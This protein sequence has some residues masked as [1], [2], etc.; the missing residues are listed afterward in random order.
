M[1]LLRSGYVAAQPSSTTSTGQTRPLTAWRLWGTLM[2]RVVLFAGWQALFALGFAVSGSSHPWSDSAAWWLITAALANFTSLGLLAWL[3][4]RE[5][6]RLVSLFNLNHKTWRRDL[7]WLVGAVAVMAPLG[8]LPSLLL[9]PAL[10]GDPSAVARIMFQPLPLWAVVTAGFAFPLS[11]A[12]SELPTYYGYVMPRLK[13]LTGLGWPVILMVATAHAFQHVALP[14]VFDGHFVVY[15]FGMFLPF[16]IFIAWLI[17]RRP[18]LLP[19][20]MDVHG[21]LYAQLI[22]Q[23]PH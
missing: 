16:A 6:R 5:G 23:I 8:F 10:F 13:A 17:N 21:L 15:R 22:F 9:A 20:L 14:L 3:S 7:L 18:S 2:S 11:I 19:Y 12:L 1:A 4:R